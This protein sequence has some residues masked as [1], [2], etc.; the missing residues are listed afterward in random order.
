MARDISLRDLICLLDRE[1]QDTRQLRLNIP[2]TQARFW[3]DFNGILAIQTVERQLGSRVTSNG[4]PRPSV[5]LMKSK[6]L[7][8]YSFPK[9]LEKYSVTS[10]YPYNSF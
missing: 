9:V 7:T 3:I 4:S 6:L 2:S 5:L 10:E 1:L 8:V